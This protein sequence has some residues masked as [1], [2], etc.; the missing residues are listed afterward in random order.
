MLRI[1]TTPTTPLPDHLQG[2]FDTFTDLL[3][4]VY[5][6]GAA[7]ADGFVASQAS[8]RKRPGT[9]DFPS[10]A[11]Y[12]E[13]NSHRHLAGMLRVEVYD[14]EEDLWLP[15]NGEHT[16]S[17]CSVEVDDITVVVTVDR[18]L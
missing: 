2:T 7:W 10:A 1:Q 17:E 12:A 5:I 14:P 16:R 18:V 6:E 3:Q 9:R 13:N 4:A 11:I 8:P 15:L